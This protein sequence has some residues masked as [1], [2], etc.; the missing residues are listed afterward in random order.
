MPDAVLVPLA[1]TRAGDWWRLTLVA[2]AGSTFGG[3]VSY[4]VGRA[5]AVGPLLTRLPLVRP[6]MV[7]AADAWL[8]REGPAGVR[9]QPLSGV[10]F[11]VFA[12]LAGAR[13]VSPAPFLCWAMAARGSRFAVAA[14]AA[15]LVGWRLK[16]F[17]RRHRLPLL[18]F[19]STT[20]AISL[21]RTVVAWERRTPGD[22]D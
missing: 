5:A 14:G 22:L 10:P 21:W 9:H 20:F 17:V 12:L 16:A 15:A 13:R 2:M 6:A 19:W 8:A 11:K 1:A 7:S 4:A 18:G 3:V